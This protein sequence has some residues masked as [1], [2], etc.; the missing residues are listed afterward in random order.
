MLKFKKNKP[1]NHSYTAQTRDKCVKTLLLSL[2][3]PII[4]ALCYAPI[5]VA[6]VALIDVLTLVWAI[7]KPVKEVNDE[8][9]NSID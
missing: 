8:K 1:Q 6:L 9:N 2:C 3:V 5:W 7:R 4:I